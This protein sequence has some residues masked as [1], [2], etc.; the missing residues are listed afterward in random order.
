[1]PYDSDVS[2]TVATV[3]AELAANAV[4]HGR[5]P[6]RDFELRLVLCDGTVR[7]EVSDTR[8]ER[9]PPAPGDVTP[10]EANA[11]AGRG[12]LLVQALSRA[13]GVTPR[14]VG[15][16]VWSEIPVPAAPASSGESG[17]EFGEADRGGAG[18]EQAVEACLRQPAAEGPGPGVVAAVVE[19]LGHPAGELLV[20]PGTA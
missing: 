1:V 12:L 20:V 3:V 9:H 7:I 14:S 6:G 19:H 11:E 16:T 18:G 15:K 2:E 4:T 10:P 13:W 8:T 5:V 17:H